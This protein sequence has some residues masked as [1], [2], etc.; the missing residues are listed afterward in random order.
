MKT[1]P[2]MLTIFERKNGIRVHCDYFEPRTP[3]P[4]WLK[5]VASWNESETTVV[6][7]GDGR[8]LKNKVQKRVLS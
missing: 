7:C 1:Y 2:K 4:E 6:V 5:V 8:I 3:D